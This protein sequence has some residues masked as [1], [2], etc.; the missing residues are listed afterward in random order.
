MGGYA[1]APNWNCSK[2]GTL[3]QKSRIRNRY[4][5]AFPFAFAM[6]SPD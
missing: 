4:F 1:E 6:R 2:V 3:S 5:P